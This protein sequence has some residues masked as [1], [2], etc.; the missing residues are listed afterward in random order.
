MLVLLSLDAKQK[1]EPSA[2]DAVVHPLGSKSF[3]AATNLPQVNLKESTWTV[4]LPKFWFA[5]FARGL[6]ISIRKN[7]KCN[8]PSVLLDFLLTEKS[9]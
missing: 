2:E 9:P 7:R 4:V 6:F 3:P 8:A 5:P 1:L